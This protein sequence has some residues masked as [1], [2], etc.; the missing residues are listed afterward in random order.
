MIPAGWAD[1][2]RNWLARLKAAGYSSATLKTRY[3]QIALVS[4]NVLAAS[5]G[6]VTTDMLVD[7]FAS[8]D[9][10]LETRKGFRNACIGFFGWLHTSGQIGADP[11]AG[12]PPVQRAKPKPK[13]CPDKV[14]LQA[15]AQATDGERLMIRLGAECGLRR[16][17][18]AKVRS[19]D[20]VEDL[21]GHSL[22]VVGKGGV[23]RLV[24][25]P[26]DLAQELLAAGGYVFPGRFGGHVEESYIG[27]HVSRLLGPEYTCHS[28]RHRY[29]TKSYEATHDLMLVS[30][31]LGHASTET[32]QRYVALSED[33][34]RAAADA[35]RIA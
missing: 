11:S 21:L 1:Y 26:E 6:D 14:I 18:I 19:E 24:P 8:R 3:H 20:V 5:P 22:R 34:M 33:R 32:T 23:L 30:K 13:P 29:A 12:L 10:A 4:I 35:V 28:L 31:L 2:I 9:W 25:L 17:E 15:L 16:M 27:S 7:W